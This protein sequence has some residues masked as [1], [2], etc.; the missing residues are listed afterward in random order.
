MDKCPIPQDCPPPVVGRPVI[1]AEVSEE[2]GILSG[3]NRQN[4]DIPVAICGSAI[5]T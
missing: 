3:T 4:Y 5:E 1:N 2:F